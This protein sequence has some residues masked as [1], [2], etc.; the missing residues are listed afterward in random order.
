M[1][2]AERVQLILA[3]IKE[4]PN[5]TVRAMVEDLGISKNTLL[6]IIKELQENGTVKREGSARKGRWVML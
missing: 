2:R 5:I 4:D 1:H 3:A 6:Q